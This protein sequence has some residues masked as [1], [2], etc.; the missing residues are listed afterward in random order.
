[1]M[2]LHAPSEGVRSAMWLPP[3]EVRLWDIKRQG[4][5]DT[6]L[7]EL[8][9]V[10]LDQLVEV[11]KQNVDSSFRWES[12]YND[13]HHLQW[14]AA[15]Y[16]S[17]DDPLGHEFRELARRRALMP[18]LFHNWLHILTT[19]PPKPSPEV[20]RHAIDAE[21]TARDLAKTAQ[22]AV[23]LTRIKGIP[24]DKLA[25]RLDQEYENYTVCI[26]NAR[27]VPL[28]FQLLKL[29]ELE[30]G[31]IEEMLAANKRLGKLALHRPLVRSRQ[32][33]AA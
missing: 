10:D 27:L 21:R 11:G 20:M 12:P 24:E 9:M 4:T 5:I 28:E 29:E 16:P 3:R 14:Y 23:K 19:V 15:L 31:S 22:K 7:D 17:D 30:A 18:R 8:G 25:I 26:E 6:P 32:I 1:M 13:V 2:R 33:L